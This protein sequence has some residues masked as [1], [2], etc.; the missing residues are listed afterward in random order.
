ME[1]TNVNAYQKQKQFNGEI[2]I[3]CNITDKEIFG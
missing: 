3:F 1:L 2:C